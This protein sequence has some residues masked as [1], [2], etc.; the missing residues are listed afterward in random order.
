MSRWFR[1]YEGTVEDGKFR[2]V[3]RMSRVTV[4]DV[5]ALWAVLLE[6]AASLDHRGIC[7][8]NESFMASVLDFKDGVVERILAAMR[9][10]GMVSG[11][12]GAI[13]IIN[14]GKRQ[15]ES[16]TDP[17]ASRRKRE[18]RERDAQARHANVTRDTGGS[19]T[20]SERKKDAAHTAPADLEKDLFARGKQVAGQGAGG[21]IAKLLKAK[22]GNVALARAAIELAATKQNP[23]EYLGA[24]IAGGQPSEDGKRLTN[25]EAYWGVG[26]TPGIM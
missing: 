2:A 9:D 11:G 17:T 12:T 10:A 18:Q 20:E 14:W 22:G 6:D 5:I 4:R 24:V 8:R 16:D 15:F 25:D 26:R 21:L 13:T 1:W 19:D 7:V 23:R 3:S